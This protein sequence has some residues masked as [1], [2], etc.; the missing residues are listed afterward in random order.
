MSTRICLL[1]RALNAL[2]AAVTVALVIGAFFVVI[3]FA[4]RVALL[5]MATLVKVG[6]RHFLD[7]VAAYRQHHGRASWQERF[8]L[9]QTRKPL[10]SNSSI[11]SCQP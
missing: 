2:S 6:Q 7:V 4:S 8:E 5:A 11:Q 1:R 3:R 9:L 10:K